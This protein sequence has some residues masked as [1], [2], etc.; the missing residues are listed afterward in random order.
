[1]ATIKKK[2]FAHLT[3]EYMWDIGYEL[4]LSEEARTY[5]MYFNEVALE[6]TINKETGEVVKTEIA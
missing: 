3:K 1:M 6:I 5:L 2:V 4:N